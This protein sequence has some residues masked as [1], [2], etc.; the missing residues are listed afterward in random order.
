MFHKVGGFLPSG[1]KINGTSLYKKTKQKNAP[2][3]FINLS[4]T[5]NPARSPF[6]PLSEWFENSSPSKSSSKVLSWDYYD[7]STDCWEEGAHTPYLL[8]V[9]L[10]YYGNTLECF[11]DA[12]EIS[13]CSESG[14]LI[15]VG[16]EIRSYWD[17]SIII[18][19]RADRVGWTPQR[20]P[21]TVSS[22]FL[23]CLDT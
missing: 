20:P 1:T 2:N 18:L 16:T 13:N 23:G 12:K 4:K 8:P 17:E 6:L 3:I 10:W 14:I 15:E 19:L 22:L 5:Q 21:G 11:L 9:Q 7:N